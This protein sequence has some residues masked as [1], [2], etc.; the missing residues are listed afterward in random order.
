MVLAAEHLELLPL[1]DLQVRLDDGS[2]AIAVVAL[3]TMA[4]RLLAETATGRTA[5]SSPTH[6]W[7][8]DAAGC[9]WR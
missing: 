6:A 1:L 2:G 5:A 4:A 3:L 8:C 7:R 9:C